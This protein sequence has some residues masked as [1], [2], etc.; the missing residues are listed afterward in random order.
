MTEEQRIAGLA[1]QL[2]GLSETAQTKFLKMLPTEE[3]EKVTRWLI[4]KFVPD[5]SPD[6]VEVAVKDEMA[7]LGV[8]HASDDK[9]ASID[10]Q[11]AR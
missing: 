3:V 11:R 2:A 10:L 5:L 9:S 4:E 1:M 8:E 6:Q 7:K